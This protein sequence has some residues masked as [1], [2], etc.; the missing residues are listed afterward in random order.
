MNARNLIQTDLH[1]TEIYYPI[2]NLGRGYFQQ[3]KMKLRCFLRCHPQV[4]SPML[5][6]SYYRFRALGLWYHDDYN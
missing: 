6:T 5:F 1:T 2:Y 3:L 4:Q